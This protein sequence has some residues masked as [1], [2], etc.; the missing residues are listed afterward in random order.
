MRNIIALYAL[1]RS[2]IFWTFLIL[3]IIGMNLPQDIQSVWSAIAVF[4]IGTMMAMAVCRFFNIKVAY[5]I[6]FCSLIAIV[7]YPI[8]GFILLAIALLLLLSAESVQ[9]S[10]KVSDTKVSKA[11]RKVKNPFVDPVTIDEQ[12]DV[13]PFIKIRNA[14]NSID[15]NTV[16]SR[17]LELKLVEIEDKADMRIFRTSETTIEY[18]KEMKQKLNSAN[19]D[20]RRSISLQELF[21]VDENDA[22]EYENEYMNTE[23]Q[24]NEEPID[25]NNVSELA[26]G[27]VGYIAGEALNKHNRIKK[28]KKEVQ[29]LDN[30]YKF[31]RGYA[32]DWDE[33]EHLSAEYKNDE[34]KYLKARKEELQRKNLAYDQYLEPDEIDDEGF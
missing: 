6:L 31:E 20:N 27:A 15:I 9:T 32:P 12:I 29:Q 17:N 4:V 28:L 25:L 11:P 7:V 1:L 13:E 2:P 18:L 21:G 22:Q 33:D 16:N 19:L 26:F 23:S 24:E 3:V 34:E 14:I 30:K 8:L 10:I 5:G